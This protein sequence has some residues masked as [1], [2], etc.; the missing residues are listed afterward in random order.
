MA[1]ADS[2]YSSSLRETNP[3]TALMADM[4]IDGFD[5]YH[6]A[7]RTKLYHDQYQHAWPPRWERVGTK[8]PAR[9]QLL[10]EDSCVIKVSAIYAKY[11][12]IFK[13]QTTKLLSWR[14]YISIDFM[15]TTLL[16]SWTTGRPKRHLKKWRLISLVI[17]SRN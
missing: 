1:I 12:D 5:A 8:P 2:I 15:V 13:K 7:A 11:A 14:I 17:S 6:Y 9:L 16:F 4:H 3:Y 10:C